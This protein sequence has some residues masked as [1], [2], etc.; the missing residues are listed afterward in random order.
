MYVHGHTL[1]EIIRQINKQ[2]RKDRYT[3]KN[4]SKY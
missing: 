4:N 2:K 3:L 1:I